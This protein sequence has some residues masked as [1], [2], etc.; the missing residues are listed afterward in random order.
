[1]QQRRSRRPRRRRVLAAGAALAGSAGALVV[2]E[3][4]WVVRRRLPSVVGMDASGFVPGGAGADRGPGRTLRMVIL[5]DSTLTGPGLSSPEE[6]WV[7]QAL[8]DLDLPAP[9]EV[10]SLAVGGSRV[11]DV[12]RRVP[13]ALA[14]GPD[15]ALVAVG[16]NDAIHGTPARRFAADLDDVLVSLL[17]PVPVVAVS[18]VGDL[19]NVARVPRPLKSVLRRR[20][21]SICRQVEE[22]VSRHERAVLLDVTPSNPGFRDRGVF[23]A[24]LF[25]PNRSG[26]A[27][28][29]T[30]ARSGLHAAFCTLGEDHAARRTSS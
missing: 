2:G 1:M 13:D 8:A 10:V 25:H 22:V 6:I 29:A 26:H 5:G 27:L 11:A 30:A 17:G 14:V 23:S 12:R 3:A 19:G 21:R 28:W 24:D 7:R 4:V 15:V 20:S 9:V 18:N 16:S